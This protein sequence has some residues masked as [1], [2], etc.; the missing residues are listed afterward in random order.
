V[1]YMT[2]TEHDEVRLEVDVD[3]D[4]PVPFV[5]SELAERTLHNPAT[6]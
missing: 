6:T 1:L 2:T 3:L 4:A 5:L